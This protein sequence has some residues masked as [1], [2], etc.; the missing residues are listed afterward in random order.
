VGSGRTRASRLSPEER[1]RQ[2][3]DCAIHVFGRRGLDRGGHAEVASEAGVAVPTVFAYF[4]T[5]EELRAAVLNAVRDYYETMADRYHR[6]DLPAAR[7]LF[8]NLLAFA[9]SVDTHPDYARIL[10]D[11]S[12]AI[13]EDVWSLYLEFYD[14]M[15]RRLEATIRRGQDEGS[16]PADLEVEGTAFMM[17]GSAFMVGQLKFTR[18]APEQVQRF[19]LTLLRAAV[20][21]EA[22]AAALP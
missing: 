3:L 5:R 2:L 9:A 12:T 15:V 10:L 14:R 7:V 17:V 13:R 18:Q 6:A 4:R 1:R 16:I 8:D 21:R 22:V 19:L 11:W 20:G